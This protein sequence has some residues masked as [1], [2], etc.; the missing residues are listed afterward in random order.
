MF[1]LRETLVLKTLKTKKKKKKLAPKI[2]EKVFSKNPKFEAFHFPFK[3][4]KKYTRLLLLRRSDAFTDS[5]RF[6]RKLNGLNSVPKN[7]TINDRKQ[8]NKKCERVLGLPGDETSGGEKRR[9]RGRHGSG[10][11]EALRD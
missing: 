8:K 9:R 7:P 3:K 10:H 5:D 6:R 4:K 11:E 2:T 1:A